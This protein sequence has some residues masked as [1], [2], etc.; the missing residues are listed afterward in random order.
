MKNSEQRAL[1]RCVPSM[2]IF[3]AGL[4]LFC[5]MCGFSA[6]ETPK[7][8]AVLAD[9]A[10][11]TAPANPDAS[12]SLPI[13]HWLEVMRRE[14][15]EQ[16]RWDQAHPEDRDMYYA[17]SIYL[18]GQ[19][20]N[21]KDVPPKFLSWWNDT[22]VAGFDRW[23]AE[24]FPLKFD[25][26]HLIYATL[27]IVCIRFNSPD[28]LGHPYPDR[29][30]CQAYVNG[31]AADGAKLLK[32]GYL[33]GQF[34][35]AEYDRM[36][37]Y[38]VY[39]YGME[40]AQ[41]WPWNLGLTPGNPLVPGDVAPDFTLPKLQA[42]LKSPA[43]SDLH[44][45][46]RMRIFH[47]EVAAE[48]LQIMDGYE[49]DPKEP[50]H[51]RPKPYRCAYSDSVTLSASRGKKP[52]CLILMDGADY[53]CNS[54][55]SMWEPLYQATK[56]QVDWY[57]VNI[58]M[59]DYRTWIHNFFKPDTGLQDYNHPIAIETRA[60]TAK[61]YC[62]Q[63]P[64]ISIPFLL[65]DMAQHTLNA[66][67]ADGGNAVT[68]LIDKNGLITYD[69]RQQPIYDFIGR[70][71]FPYDWK[72]QYLCLL[73]AN[74]K[75]LLAN[76]G[77]WTGKASVMPDWHRPAYLENVS[78]AQV[79]PAAGTLT[80]AG[81]DKKATVMEVDQRT[82]I[83]FANNPG[84]GWRID[85]LTPADLAAGTAAS[86]VYEADHSAAGRTADMVLLGGMTLNSDVGDAEAK[87]IYT[88]AIVTEIKDSVITA[89]LAP[90]PKTQIE[91]LN[92][93]QQAGDRAENKTS[94]TAWELPVIEDLVARPDQPLTIH[95]DRGTEVIING[96]MGK[97]S[98]LRAGDF[99]SFD[100]KPKEKTDNLWP[101][102]I[103]VYRF[104]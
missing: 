41:F 13:S 26:D 12:V 63:Y 49:A 22:G 69:S 56:D 70:G 94:N 72:N 82:R 6:G 39:V 103:R 48:L 88:P 65:D 61:M 74:L 92:F 11:A 36:R 76:G 75:D 32:K 58:T 7:P 96:M 84:N 52:V 68:F 54:V 47:S 16:E 45:F 9:V 89:R 91:G 73:E 99:V 24:G 53:Y 27:G 66:Y 43:Y 2:M 67:R 37:L 97:L 90:R 87:Y 30:K 95:V 78:I 17:V 44:T 38:A 28:I 50:D 29:A 102:I 85:R 5:T 20:G 15:A 10:P 40:G 98:D 77:V 4:L 93:W 31:F 34:T 104:K 1:G 101:Y 46:E 86:I 18:N 42:V 14:T 62:M 35:R 23:A 33:T 25:R 71:Q 100:I 81:A 59:H 51:I 8:P 21:E 3:G 83:L 64:N 60:Q 57:F 79:N 80:V 55:S 19:C